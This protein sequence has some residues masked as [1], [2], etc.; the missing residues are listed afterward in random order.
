MPLRAMTQDTRNSFGHH[1]VNFSQ[2]TFVPYQFSHGSSGSSSPAP[3]GEETFESQSPSQSN[4]QSKKYDKWTNEQ[5]KYLVQLWAEKQDVLNSKDARNAWRAIA[6][7][8]NNKFATNKTVEKCMRKIKYIIDAYKERKEWNR[9]Q[10][11]GSLRKSVSY[12]E[13][14]A[15]LGCHDIVTLKNVQEAG[16]SSST[17]SS[18]ASC[19]A[20]SESPLN[21]SA[22]SSI[23]IEPKG[24]ALPLKSCLERKK[25]QGKRKRKPEDADGE[26][27]EHFKRAYDEIKSQG[28][29]VASSMEK[30]QELQMQQMQIM[31]QF[32][33]NFLQAFKDK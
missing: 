4:Q 13:I 9:N 23:E 17:T 20:D 28:E 8:I 31:N 1:E 19:S 26:M 29:R 12:D 2:P 15:V 21:V 10:T 24:S 32:M 6:E 25:G 7:E 14:D 3:L 22:E 33:G 5:Q 30:M 11:G 18:T 16:D 27:E